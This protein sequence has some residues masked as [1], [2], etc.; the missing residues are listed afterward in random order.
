M[1]QEFKNS[2]II[3]STPV[4][5][6]HKFNS[7]N[8]SFTIPS[9]I[10][11]PHAGRS[12]IIAQN[13]IDQL[14]NQNR[15]VYA[16]ELLPATPETAYTSLSDLI[17]AIQDC[18]IFINSEVNLIGICQG[19]W[20]G[21]IYTALNPQDI[22]RYAN[23]AGPINTKT[24]QPNIIENYC[25]IPNILALHKA[26]LSANSNIQPGLLQWFAFSIVDPSAVYL[27][28][29]FDLFNHLSTQNLPAISKWLTN[30]T[31]YDSPQDL[32][33]TWF[34]DCLENHF[35]ENKLFSGQWNVLGRPVD[36]SAITCP[37]YLYAGAQDKIT[38]PFQ[39]FDMAHKISGHSHQTLFPSAGHTRCFTGSRELSLFIQTFF[40]N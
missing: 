9:L 18:Q 27:K 17:R 28:R 21:A 19:A 7:N 16:F 32:A 14:V 30:N 24:N 4:Y 29:W 39:V 33:G 23:I 3:I 11:P 2:E 12:P 1:T 10:I 15:S 6:L 40:A 5:R 26:I 13:L 34:I 37:I 38:H 35:I 20:L 8:Q 25:Q 22:I 36:L 31:W